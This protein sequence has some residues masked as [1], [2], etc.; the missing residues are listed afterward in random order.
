[1]DQY[2]IAIVGSRDL[3][4]KGRLDHLVKIL[5]RSLLIANRDAI[6]LRAS[7]GAERLK[8]I[9]GGDE[10]VDTLAQYVATVLGINFQT[11]LPQNPR[12]EPNG[13]KARNILIAENCDELWCIRAIKSKSYGSR[14]TADYAEGLNKRV[15]RYYV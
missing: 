1:M 11:Y 7:P 12:W 2:T 14:W 9:T 10:G 3:S 4:G 15:L 6:T 13:Y 5:T 8:V